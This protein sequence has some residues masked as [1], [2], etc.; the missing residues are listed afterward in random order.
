MLELMGSAQRRSS[1]NRG[2]LRFVK[3]SDVFP[4]F[5]VLLGVVLIDVENA[6]PLS[7]VKSE[8]ELRIGVHP[9]RW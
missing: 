1:M 8:H 3:V 2:C 7:V 9:G 4:V 6:F 5:L